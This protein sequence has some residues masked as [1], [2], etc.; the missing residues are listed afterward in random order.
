M[1]ARLVPAS[2]YRVLEEITPKAMFDPDSGE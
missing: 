1:S 2:V